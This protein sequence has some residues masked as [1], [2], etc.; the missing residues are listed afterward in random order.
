VIRAG[1]GIIYAQTN[2]MAQ[3]GL[4]FGNDF[5]SGFSYAQNINNTTNGALPVWLL[6][7]GYPAFNGTLPQQDPGI[8]VGARR[9]LCCFRQR[10]VLR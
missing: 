7:N 4:Q 9:S 5:Q 2:A 6:D 3:G 10:A 8:N 1:F